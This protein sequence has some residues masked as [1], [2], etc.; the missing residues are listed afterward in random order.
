MSQKLISF[1]PTATDQLLIDLLKDRGFKNN[2]DIIRAA[3]QQLAVSK[4]EQQVYM[5]A[6]VDGYDKELFQE[7]K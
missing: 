6:L 4:L 2:A 7:V 1:K 5:Q 3:I